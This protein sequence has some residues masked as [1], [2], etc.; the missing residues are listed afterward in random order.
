MD[1]YSQTCGQNFSHRTIKN[2]FHEIVKEYNWID[3]FLAYVD[4]NR[5]ERKKWIESL[6]FKQDGM[7]KILN[8]DWW[9]YKWVRH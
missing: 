6:G 8:K 9:I 5:P 7:T 3:E 1:W 4:V 2:K